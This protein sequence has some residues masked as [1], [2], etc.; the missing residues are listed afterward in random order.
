MHEVSPSGLVPLGEPPFRLTFASYYIRFVYYRAIL[1]CHLYRGTAL[2]Q[3]P[4]FASVLPV[5]PA[6]EACV[7]ANLDKAVSWLSLIL[8]LRDR[9]P[10]HLALGSF[11]NFYNLIDE[12][13]NP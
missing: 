4:V 8:F 7:S 13:R 9:K 6:L 5:Q 3:L 12:G 10:L 1:G 2:G 11:K